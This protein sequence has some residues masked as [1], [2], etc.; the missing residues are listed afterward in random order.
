[1]CTHTHEEWA[2]LEACGGGLPSH[3][4]CGSAHFTFDCNGTLNRRIAAPEAQDPLKRN[5][6]LAI[7]KGQVHSMD[8]LRSGALFLRVQG[9]LFR[10][11]F[12]VFFVIKY[13]RMPSFD[14]LVM[15][16]ILA[17]WVIPPYVWKTH[18]DVLKS[19]F[20]SFRVYEWRGMETISY[21]GRFFFKMNSSW[22]H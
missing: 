6:F 16:Q 10:N 5:P 14:C 20:K 9:W 11:L 17:F 21:D 19:D 13:L 7:L 4:W 3:S 12:S 1:M 8:G 22:R 15:S 18:S 2:S